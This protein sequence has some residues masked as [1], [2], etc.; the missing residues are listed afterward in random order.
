MSDDRRVRRALAGDRSLT[1]VR[2][3]VPAEVS[4]LSRAQGGDGRTVT[5]YAAVF[6]IPTEVHDQDGEY[7]EQIDPHAFDKTATERAA[8]VFCVYNHAKTLHGSPSDLASVPVGRPISIKPDAKGLLTVTRYNDA[9]DQWADQILSAIRNGSLRGMSFTGA[10]LRSDPPL[11]PGQRYHA[12]ARGNLRLVT[13]QEIALIEYGPTPIPYY[14]EA[15][16]V[17]VRSQSRA[18]GPVPYSQKQGENVRCPT[19]SQGAN[20]VYNMP[21]A[22]CCDQCGNML[23]GYAYPTG[24]QGYEQ[25]PGEN[26]Q[27][28]NCMRSNDADAVYCDQCGHGLPAS[29]Y[30]AAPDAVTAA[31]GRAAAMDDDDSTDD[32]AAA[33]SADD[34]DGDDAERAAA[35][36][37]SDWDA[38]K[39]WHNG[40]EADDPAAFYAGICAGEKAGDKSTQDAWAL[41]YKYTPSSPPNAA[42]VKNALS[43]LPQ[44]EGLTNAAEAKKTLQAAMKRVSPDYEPDGSGTQGSRAAAAADTDLTGHAPVTGRHTHSHSAFGSQGGDA[45]HTHPH[46]HDGDAAH[47]HS[48]Q[49]SP[50][51]GERGTGTP[52]AEKT[53]PPTHSATATTERG[54]AMADDRMTVAERAARVEEIV[55]RLGDIDSEYAGAELPT[56]TRSEWN[57]LLEE[58]VLHEAAIRDA[59]QR[60]QTLSALAQNPN[61]TIGGTDPGSGY[62]GDAALERARGLTTDVPPVREPGWRSGG[63]GAITGRPGNIW[64]LTE[65]RQRSRSPEDLVREYR[66]RA[67]RSLDLARFPGEKSRSREDVQAGIERLLAVAD[68]RQATFARHM[69]VT[70]DPAYMR[71]FEKII[72]RGTTLTLTGSEQAAVQ[73]ALEMGTSA[74]WSSGS[75]PVPYQLDPTVTLTSNGAINAIRQIS[76]VEQIVGKEWLGVT[77]A[78][79]TVSRAN[80]LDEATDGSPTLVQPG[81]QP[82]RV[83]AFVPFSVEVEQDWNGLMA[84]ISMMLADAK[85]VEEAGTFATGAGTGDIPQGIVTALST[86]SGTAS[87]VKTAGTAT[88]AYGDVYAVEDAVPPRFRPQASWLGSKTAYN[89]ARQAFTQ[90]ASAAGDP[91]VRPSAGTPAELIGYPVFENSVM[92]AALTSGKKLL[93]LGDFKQFI[94]VDRV[95]MSI[96]LVPHVFGGTS[97]YPTGQRGIYAL[98]RNSSLCLTANAFRMMVTL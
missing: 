13:R 93:I 79:I 2:A 68:D 26:V 39:A 8:S 41:P 92:D 47:S 66:D 63:V 91:W 78:G 4:I 95:G 80:E 86:G 6:N 38:S 61:A 89:F 53:E 60:A 14:E 65:A 67:M 98:W 29:A 30:G 16:V 1:V 90:E 81:V 96:E 5:A 15:Q 54:N 25:Q 56:D 9:A 97:N 70:S 46:E 28:Q 88:V 22:N 42:G 57:T 32:D 55:R 59:T 35:V 19:C 58:R 94:I 37:N 84:E 48:H 50:P 36:D 21:D 12:D 34:P 82:T 23:P 40:A 11:R 75:Y 24:R 17:G 31:A 51:S 43:R 44:T 76:R 72:T 10:F 71:A 87:E 3:V 74:S 18:S 77:S 52:A 83:Q 73:R 62:D 85:D 49:T 69:L 27:C 20:A 64:D 45:T 33:E 7:L